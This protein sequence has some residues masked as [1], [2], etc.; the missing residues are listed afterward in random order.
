MGCGLNKLEKRDEKRPGNIY[1]TLKR[2]QVE[3]KVD[4]SYEYRFL[5][6]T[7]LS[8][9]EL[10]RSS[11][12]RLTSLRDLPAQLLELYQQGF[13]LAALHPFVQPT[14]MREKMPLEHIFRAILV[15]KTDRSQKTDLHNEGYILEID[16]CSSLDH[17]KLIPD[18]VKKVQDA[19]SRGLQFVGVVPQSHAPVK[20]VGISL[21]MPPARDA[22]TT[23]GSPAALENENPGTAPARLDE[24]PE[25][26]LASMEEASHAQHPNS[27]SG[28]G[29]GGELSL[30][31]LSLT[32]DGPEGDP[33][34][35]P[36]GKMEIFALFNRPKSHPKCRQ[37]YPVTIPLRVSKNGQAGS[38]L[39]ANWLE[40]MSDHFRKGGMLVNAVFHLAMANDS[41]HGLTDGVFIFEAVSTEDSKTIQG[42]DAIVVEQ[43]T[44]LEGAEVQTDYVPLLNS[45]AA[46]GWQLTCVLPT[47]VVKT[48]RE[49]SVSTK[50]IVFLQ[51][52]CLPQKIKKKESKFQWRFSREEM[53]SRQQRKS[54]GKFRN[55]QHTEENEK[56]LEDQFSKGGNMGNCVWGRQQEG[57]ACVPMRGP[58]P[59]VRGEGQ[60]GG[61]VQNG[62]AGHS[63]APAA[64]QY[65]DPAEDV[66]VA[67]QLAPAEEN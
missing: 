62:P 33:S 65:S 2:P 60:G 17:Q 40:H 25:L 21:P 64:P 49:G 32:L 50:Q 5:E 22:E 41:L 36:L 45:L 42:Y 10:P 67:A 54:K 38:S 34:D 43:W 4:V 63:R 6:F 44:V 59:E 19:A 35:G 48:A 58:V 14:H 53:H 13:S 27:P 61:A 24:S 23:C 15:K 11:A 20:S 56:N 18:F 3:T 28:E 9:E 51:R 55:K 39:D 31:G 26:S 46:Y 29:V 8:A 52:P 47:P 16:C 1:S 57:G 12:V 66:E 30:Q 7:T 37:Y